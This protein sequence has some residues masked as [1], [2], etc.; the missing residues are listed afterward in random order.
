MTAK[1]TK[2][3]NREQAAGDFVNLYC[4][5]QINTSGGLCQVAIRCFSTTF[6]TQPGYR[7]Y[8]RRMVKL[9]SLMSK[10]SG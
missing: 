10:T 8:L 1:V 4:E 2:Y 7:S 9:A 5:V 6:W 3:P